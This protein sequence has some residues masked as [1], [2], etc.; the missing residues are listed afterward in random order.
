MSISAVQQCGSAICIH[1]SPPSEVSLPTPQFT[2]LGHHRALSLASCATHF[3]MLT[4]YT[5]LISIAKHEEH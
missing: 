1:I 2:P 5:L 3:L 4:V